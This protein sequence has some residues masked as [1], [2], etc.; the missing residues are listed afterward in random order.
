M[1]TADQ[2]RICDEILTY[3]VEHR[4]AQDTFE[5]IVE[6]WLLEQGIKRR[7]AEVKEALA[8]LVAKGLVLGRKGKDSRTHYRINRL[9]YQE[10]LAMLKQKPG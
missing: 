5:G 2:S 6:W 7:T 10:I 8:Q 4:N 9:K 3:L 1:C